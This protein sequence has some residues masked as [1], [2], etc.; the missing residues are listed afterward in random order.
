M[1]HR[2]RNVFIRNIFERIVIVILIHLGS[3]RLEGEMEVHACDQW[4][5]LTLIL[6]SG[7][8]VVLCLRGEEGS[9]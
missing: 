4:S 2:V 3:M 7:P 8:F 6:T 5:A 9:E 1:L